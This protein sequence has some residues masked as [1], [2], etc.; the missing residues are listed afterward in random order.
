MEY[1]LPRK[2]VNKWIQWAQEHKRS[3]PKMFFNLTLTNFNSV[4]MVC[5]FKSYYPLLNKGAK[6]LQ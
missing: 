5:I 6:L 4:Y 3:G 1:E 2:P